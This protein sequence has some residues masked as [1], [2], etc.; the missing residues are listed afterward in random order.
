METV[1][2]PGW[3]STQIKAEA[4][5][6]FEAGA[7]VFMK[8]TIERARAKRPDALWGYYHFPYCYA[9]GSVTSC[10]SQ[11]QDENDSLKWLFDACDVLYPSVYVP[12]S[13]TQAQQKQYVKNNLDEAFRVRDEVSP[14]TKIVPYVMNKYRDTFNFMTEGDMNA[15]IATVASYDV[16]AVIIWGRYS[17]ANTATTCGDLY[18]YIDTVLGPIL[19]QFY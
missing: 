18:N 2:H 15:T 17:D 3:T 4:K 8:D 12:E 6:N 1:N 11:V 10:S 14:G 9:N 5:I 13:Y 19:T 7:K 16:D